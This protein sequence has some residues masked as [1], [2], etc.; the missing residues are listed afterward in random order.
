MIYSHLAAGGIL[1]CGAFSVSHKTRWP[2]SGR[3]NQRDT[4]DKDS[5]VFLS[6]HHDL[7][8]KRSKNSRAQASQYA[9]KIVHAKTS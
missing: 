4:D 1:P 3:Q 6:V 5:P 2:E 8:C 7:R 9:I